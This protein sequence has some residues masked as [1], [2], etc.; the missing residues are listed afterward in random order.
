MSEDAKGINSVVAFDTLY[1]NN[2][3]Q[4]LKILLPYIAPP[5]QRKYAVLIKYLELRYTMEYVTTSP[6][7]TDFHAKS[8]ADIDTIISLCNELRVYSSSDEIE[9]LDQLRD[10]LC[11]FQSAREMSETLSL[12][13][14]LMPDFDSSGLNTPFTSS[15]D[16][17]SSSSA[18]DST[19]IVSTEN[20]IFDILTQMLTP[21]QKNL[22]DYFQTNSMPSSDIQS[23]GGLTD[24]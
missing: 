5:M 14:E 7:Q 16:S 17:E 9:N 13:K 19:H 24:E 3:I 22:F 23:K 21:E 12:M 1:T 18:D 4:K 6:A 2:Q 20:T 8:L 10:T 15:A 11:S